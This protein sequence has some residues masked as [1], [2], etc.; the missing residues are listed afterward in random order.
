MPPSGDEIARLAETM[1][2][3]LR[4]LEDADAS[5]RRFVSDASHELRSPLATI[6]A[7]MEVDSPS[8]AGAGDESERDALVMAEVLRMQQ[9]VGDLLTL[10]KADDGGVTTIHEDVDVD[11]LVDAEVRRLRMTG[12]L[13]ISA[14]IEPARVVGDRARLAQAVRN[15]VDN[16]A[17]H[18]RSSVHLSVRT[19]GD[20]VVLVVDNDGPLIPPED[21]ELVFE[22]FSRLEDS[23]DRDA[24]G[25]GLGLAIVQTFVAAHAGTVTAQESPT[26]LCRFEV[27][28]PAPR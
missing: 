18:A 20:D 5:S 13:T 2:L 3:M 6:R 12:R 19:E 11:D 17:R 27:R 23:R 9:L 16:A 26:G 8:G 28:L 4:R 1:N 15:L 10:A 24:G 7:V 25:S 14:T 21:R 22:R